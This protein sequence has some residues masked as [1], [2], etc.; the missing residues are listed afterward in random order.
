MT[1][2]A[3]YYHRYY[4]SHPAFAYNALKF[5]HQGLVSIAVSIKENKQEQEG[6]NQSEVVIIEDS[7]PQNEVVVSIEDSGLRN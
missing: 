1:C 7:I 4:I 5:T 6:E 3:F 2:Y